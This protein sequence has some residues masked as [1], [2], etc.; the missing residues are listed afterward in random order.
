MPVKN[1]RT[2]SYYAMILPRPSPRVN[3]RRPAPSIDARMSALEATIAA[4]E[5]DR[6]W[7]VATLA[8]LAIDFGR[9]QQQQQ[10]ETRP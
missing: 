10:Q 2:K 6:R 9:L 3:P 1:P 5:A 8:D 4:F 7:L